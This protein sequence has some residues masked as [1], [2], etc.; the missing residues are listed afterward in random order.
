M[1]QLTH[2]RSQGRA[3]EGRR[4]ALQWLGRQLQW[5]RRLAE[6]RPG[7]DAARKAA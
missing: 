3:S 4:E 1:E 5:E 6:L 2:L 7:T